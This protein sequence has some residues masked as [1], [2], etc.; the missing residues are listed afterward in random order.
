MFGGFGKNAEMQA[1]EQSIIAVVSIGDK[2]NVTFFNKAA[3]KLWGYERDEV[4]GQNVSKLVPESLRRGHDDYVNRHRAGGENRIVGTSREV[5][6]QRKD[7]K[8]TWALLSLSQIEI[9]GKKHYT[10]F[11]QDVTR[12]REAREMMQQTLSQALDAVVVINEKNEITFYNK[13]AERLWGYTAAEVLG[14]SIADLS[15]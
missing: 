10:A 15:G 3:E 14:M 6:L 2:N 13:A 1:L 9:H 7:G 5:Q 11:V 12:E 8:M 4:I